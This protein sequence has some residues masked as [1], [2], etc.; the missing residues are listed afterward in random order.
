MRNYTRTEF[1]DD[2]HLPWIN[3]SPNLRDSVAAILYPGLGLIETTNISVGRGTDSP[4]H[5]IGA[6]R[7]LIRPGD[8]ASSSEPARPNPAYQDAW[9]QASDVAAALTARHI[10]GVS[11]ATASV[12]IL[13]D[14]N[15]YPFHGQAIEAVRIT[16]TDRNALDSPEFGIEILAVLHK[17]YPTDFHLDRAIFVANQ[18]TMDALKRGDD[19]RTIR[20]SWQP[21][22]DAFNA[23]RAK[24]LLY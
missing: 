17:L 3:P 5:I 1:F 21:A 2:T 13:E 11:F 23:R 19:P 16:V 12:P 7:S 4:F 14:A 10:P 18:A 9:F 8:R 15:K 20:E 22:L 6:G 24:I